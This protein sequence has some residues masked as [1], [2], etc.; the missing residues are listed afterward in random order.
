[1]NLTVEALT[2]EGRSYSLAD[3]LFL[4]AL[5]EAGDN[6]SF[7]RAHAALAALRSIDEDHVL[8]HRRA[9]PS[10]I[11]AWRS[12]HQLYS[13]EETEAFLRHHELTKQELAEYL[14]G[15]LARVHASEHGIEGVAAAPH[16]A[17]LAGA[18]AAAFAGGL[19]EIVSSAALRIGLAAHLVDAGRLARAES[20]IRTRLEGFGNTSLAELSAPL[21]VAAARAEEL[22]GLE[23]RLSAL[24]D[25]LA[26]PE[27]VASEL[28]RHAFPLTVVRHALVAFATREAAAEALVC[29]HH[30]GADLMALA[31]RVGAKTFVTELRVEQLLETRHLVPVAYALA[32][33]TAGPAYNGID[34]WNVAVVLGRDAP[35]LADASVAEAVRD[36][37]VQRVLRPRVSRVTR[38]RVGFDP[39]ARVAEDDAEW[40]DDD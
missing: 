35:T 22:L 10:A 31:K 40:G 14:L 28:V 12:G 15:E 18:R 11:D 20:E 30:D 33:E 37:L 23:A 38:R 1:M 7:V 16:D 13:A 5:D 32:G 21:G 17:I 2:A 6:N 24:V 29:V 39:T 26:T 27:A 36:S 4:H 9:L 19:D 25:E 8:Q 34:A 3:A